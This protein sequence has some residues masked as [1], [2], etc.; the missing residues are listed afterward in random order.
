MHAALDIN[1][2]YDIRLSTNNL[3]FI[4]LLLRTIYEY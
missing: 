3:N 2:I 1:N 4:I